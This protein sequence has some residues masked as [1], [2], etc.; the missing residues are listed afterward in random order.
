M[1]MQ[2]KEQTLD[3]GDGATMRKVNAHVEI[4]TL[5]SRVV[6]TTAQFR[7]LVANSVHKVMKGE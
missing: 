2:T 1:I 6:L 3:L 7:R 5:F 4:I